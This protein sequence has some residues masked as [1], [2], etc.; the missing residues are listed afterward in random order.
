MTVTREQFVTECLLSI[1]K[2]TALNNLISCVAWI[3]SENSQA[4]WNPFDTEEGGQAGETNYNSVGV[5][6]YPTQAEGIAAWKATILNGFYPHILQDLGEVAIPAV[7]CSDI[8]NSAWGSKPSPQ[9]LAEVAVNYAHYAAMPIAG[10]FN[11]EPIVNTGILDADADLT[12]VKPIVAGFRSLIKGWYAVSSDGGVFTIGGAVFYGSM[13]GKPLNQPIVDAWSSPSGLGYT[14][15]AA[16]G[17]TFNFGDA[18]E[19]AL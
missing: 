4:L 9:L 10:S 18:M 1:S 13:G 12:L 5:K 6:N 8:V 17:G 2:P 14:L 7:T 11:M 16:D 3:E 15:L 19:G